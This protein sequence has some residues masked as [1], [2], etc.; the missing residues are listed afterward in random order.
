MIFPII[1][2]NVSDWIPIWNQMLFILLHILFLVFPEAA[3]TF[4]VS[5]SLCL[6]YETQQHQAKLR[7][8]YKLIGGQVKMSIH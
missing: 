5:T 2:R 3:Y 6:R 7:R 8:A 1:D 4:I